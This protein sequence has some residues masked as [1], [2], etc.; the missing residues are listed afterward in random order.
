MPPPAPE[1]ET[2]SSVTAGPYFSIAGGALWLDDAGAFGANLDFDTGYSI[3]AAVGYRWE[4][5][6]A[7]EI[8]SGYMNVDSGEVSFRGLHADVEGDFEQVPI[9]CNALYWLPMTERLQ[10]YVGSGVGVVWSSTEVDSVGGVN[11]RG[12]GDGGDDWNFAAQAKAGFA[13]EVCPGGSLTIGYRLFYG[14]DAIA[15]V[16]DSL[17]HILEGGFVWRF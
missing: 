12:L 14:H 17:G 7:L 6:L 1:P 10:F 3:L 13:F 16:D 4:Y 5:G 8:E 11:L 9:M 15:E 2:W